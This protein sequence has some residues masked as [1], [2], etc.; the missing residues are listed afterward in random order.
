MIE[1]PP[2]NNRPS[3][4]ALKLLLNPGYSDIF[5]KIDDEYLYYDKVKYLVPQGISAEE[6]WNAVKFRRS[7]SNTVSFGRYSFTFPVTT[8]MQKYL[9]EI[10][11]QSGGSILAGHTLSEKNREYYLLS[12]LMEEAIASSKME[13][14]STTRKIAKEMLRKKAS[15]KDKDQQMIVNNYNTIRFLV[16][17]CNVDLTPELLLEIHK[18]I[19][20]KTLADSSDEGHFRVDDDVL[21]MD[22]ST[23]EVIY[24]PPSYTQ[25]PDIV[26]DLCDFANKDE[27]FIHPVIKGIVIHFMISFLHP[28]ADGNGRTARSL[29][30]WYMLKKGYWL[31]EYLSISRVIYSSKSQY[32]K[33]FLYTE[34]DGYDLGY[35]IQYNLKV[36]DKAN[37]ELKVY[38]ERKQKEAE[39]SMVFCSPSGGL[40]TRQARILQLFIDK[41]DSVYTSKDLETILS[42]TA[43]TIR[44]DLNELVEKGFLEKVNLN[45]RLI[46]YRRGEL[47][48]KKVKELKEN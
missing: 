34:Y 23:G 21:V 36:M 45:Q 39:A 24:T 47:F 35:F 42:A 10:D 40:N 3:S 2:V 16:D 46:G 4:S 41:P 12:S 22:T 13:G 17:N 37:K 31:T 15:P 11:M 7:G 43:K 38:L 48:E 6:F 28:F 32:E 25:I 8:F 18:R 1:H 9:H 30:Y 5:R 29:F 44:L 14:A 26:R 19:S 20:E 27:E 33:S